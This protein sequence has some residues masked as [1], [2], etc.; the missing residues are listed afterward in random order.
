MS[1][2]VG[3]PRLFFTPGRWVELQDPSLHAPSLFQAE[4]RVS[5]TMRPGRTRGDWVGRLPSRYLRVL[6]VRSYHVWLRAR[7]LAYVW[8]V[9][10]TCLASVPYTYPT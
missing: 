10:T 9:H 1:S 2:H 3:Y 4:I 6:V 8:Y 5:K 7:Y